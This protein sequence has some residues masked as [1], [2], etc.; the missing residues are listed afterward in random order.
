MKGKINMPEE[1]D[2]GE[3]IF[4]WDD[5]GDLIA[6]AR[7]DIYLK[8]LFSYLFFEEEFHCKV[9][10]N[11]ELGYWCGELYVKWEY[12]DTYIC[13]TLEELRE[14]FEEDYKARMI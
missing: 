1:F 7:D 13:E 12:V 9:W 10:W 6:E 11:D 4:L 3:Y 5:Y 2:V 8:P 14:E